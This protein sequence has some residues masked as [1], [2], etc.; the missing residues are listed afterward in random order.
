M[1]KIR[2]DIGLRRVDWK[3]PRHPF[4]YI[5]IKGTVSFEEVGQFFRKIFRKK[6]DNK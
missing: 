1:A 2:P 3:N 4:S 6:K 5:G